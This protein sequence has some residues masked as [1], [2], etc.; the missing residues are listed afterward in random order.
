MYKSNL[1]AETNDSL[2]SP[3]HWWFTCGVCD[4]QQQKYV[5]N[6]SE[7]SRGWLPFEML[8]PC[9]ILGQLCPLQIAGPL[10]H[11]HKGTDSFANAGHQIRSLWHQNTQTVLVCVRINI[12]GVSEALW[13][14]WKQ[15]SGSCFFPPI[16]WGFFIWAKFAF[17]LIINLSLPQVTWLITHPRD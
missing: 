2:A 11:W 8:P 5:S 3:L 12:T 17:C 9:S 1:H 4:I 7:Q 15:D 16:N 6:V 14:L 13:L 10:P